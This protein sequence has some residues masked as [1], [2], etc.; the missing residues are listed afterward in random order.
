MRGSIPSSS[1]LKKYRD[2][3]LIG[4]SRPPL[5]YPETIRISVRIFSGRPAVTQAISRVIAR[6]PA[7][8][9]G[10]AFLLAYAPSCS[11]SS[12]S[13]L[14]S[15]G[16][17]AA[18]PCPVPA[19]PPDRLACP[20]R[21]VLVGLSAL[22]RR[23]QLSCRPW[24]G[25]GPRFRIAVPQARHAG[26]LAGRRSR[27]PRAGHRGPIGRHVDASWTQV[28]RHRRVCVTPSSRPCHAFVT[29]WRRCV[30]HHCSASATSPLPVADGQPV[31]RW[32]SG[33]PTPGP[34]RFP[35]RDEVPLSERASLSKG[36]AS[37]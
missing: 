4:T 11:P 8:W 36:Q 1:R 27:R 35:H 7:V 33:W 3:R 13:P 2:L 10:S 23:P 37:M 14:D 34:R 22:R 26:A 6:F 9:S 5:P 28:R 29:L 25:S 19:R 21:N 15:F 32:G 17:P 24:N 31:W 20:A 30:S 18:A 12:R 16:P